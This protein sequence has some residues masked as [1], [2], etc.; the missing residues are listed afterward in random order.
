MSET[1]T[2]EIQ[3]TKI[4]ILKIRAKSK[5][6]TWHESVIDNE[7]MNKKKSN[8]C[9]IFHRQNECY[10]CN[11]SNEESSDY[12]SDY[13]SSEDETSDENKTSKGKS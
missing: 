11:E 3:T 13:D 4:L 5:Q 8:K 1:Q 10:E 9:C 6:V 7:H 2:T 12:D